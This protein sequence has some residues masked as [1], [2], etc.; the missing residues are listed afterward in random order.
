VGG[1]DR[2]TLGVH[3]ATVDMGAVDTQQRINA[4][5]QQPAERLGLPADRLKRAIQPVV[6]VLH[7][8]VGALLNAAG[9]LLAVDHE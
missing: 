8:P 7:Q 6:V 2:H 4:R 3:A 9:P 5:A 1:H